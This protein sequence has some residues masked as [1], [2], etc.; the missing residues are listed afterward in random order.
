M[1]ARPIRLSG[2]P[3]SRTAGVGKPLAATAAC[4]TDSFRA[5]LGSGMTLATSA[6]GQPG[7]GSVSVNETSSAQNPP[8]SRTGGA[9]KVRSWRPVA[10]RISSSTSTSRPVFTVTVFTVTVNADTV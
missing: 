4:T 9:A 7:G 2:P 10:A 3:V 6:R 8:V 1:N 5:V